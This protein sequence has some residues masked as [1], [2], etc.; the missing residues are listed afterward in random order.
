ML[1]KKRF[2]SLS[3]I[4]VLTGFLSIGANASSSKLNDN[5]TSNLSEEEIALINE[6]KDAILYLLQEDAELAPYLK[7]YKDR[8]KEKALSED[9]D[10]LFPLSAED[11]KVRRKKSLE[12][13]KANNEPLINSEIKI[14]EVPY[15]PSEKSPVVLNVAANN[16]SS[17]SFFD[18][19]GNPWP[20]AGEVIGDPNSFTSSV[21]TEDKNVV[22]F[23][24]LKR[25]SESV[26]LVN[27]SGLKNLVVI[28]LRG[29]ESTVDSNKRIRLP[30]LSPIA[31][32][33]VE[34]VNISINVGNE[35]V[36][37]KLI[38]GDYLSDKSI[39]E[40][41]VNNNPNRNNVYVRQGEFTYL[42]VK[43]ELIFPE[44]INHHKSSN[45]Y[46]LYK[47]KNKD[48]ITLLA[49]G[50]YQIFTLNEK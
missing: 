18:Y 3:I 49:N 7:A 41:Y 6:K 9:L 19:E 33:A 34:P 32:K 48:T 12:I 46:N 17:I 38:S 30:K 47:I 29:N 13:E 45:G 15:D 11:I 16:P 35:P 5:S 4:G 27:L 43:N 21:F 25:F 42:R 14:S 44:T 1:T 37:D 26:A 2:L 31:E 10:K 22:V 8:A 23:S 50:E 28:R 39:K 24:I 40:L 36:F 20:I